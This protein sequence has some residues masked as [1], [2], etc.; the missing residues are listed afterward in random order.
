MHVA[1]VEEESRGPVCP[2]LLAF[3]QEE[4]G[5]K[6]RLIQAWRVLRESYWFLP[7]V[8]S[9]AALVLAAAA[10]LAD[11][12]LGPWSFDWLPGAHP[13][14][15]RALLSTV[16]GSLIT[17]AGVAISVTL[18]A[19]AS[20]ST[21]FGPRLLTIFLRDRGLQTTLGIFSASFL[22]SLVVL[23]FIRSPLESASDPGNPFVP[24]IA[25]LIAFIGGIGSIGAFIYLVHH[26][27][28]MLHVGNVVARAGGDLVRGIA[29]LQ[30]ERG[31]AEDQTQPVSVGEDDRLPSS[32]WEA[33]YADR[34]GYIQVIDNDALLQLAQ[35]WSRV[36]AVDV[37][38]GQ[39]VIAGERIARIWPNGALSDEDLAEVREA[40]AWGLRRAYGQDV[41]FQVDQI[42]QIAARALSPG[43]ND[44]FTAM[45]CVD[46]LTSAL[47]HFARLPQARWLI[48]SADGEP[49]VFRRDTT[50]EEMLEAAVGQL[51]PYAAADINAS[52]YLARSLTRLAAPGENRIPPE[53]MQ[54]YLERLGSGART[55]LSDPL[56]LARLDAVLESLGDER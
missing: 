19:L 13:D 45:T 21:Q 23:L 7:S 50:L 18:V 40:F 1:P 43:V 30:D 9:V 12:Q 36:V 37:Q 20:T 42:V 52:M 14:G 29:A 47:G 27:A 51:I 24:Q 28:Q 54:G 44:P 49:R 26:V 31:D 34:D 16:A 8:Y 15:A 4:H 33:V 6:A 2:D 48:L 56:D 38:P 10:I 5:L 3:P 41:A 53:L 46:W 11:R 22:Y 39:F 32:D 35:R 55:G 25:L 17:V